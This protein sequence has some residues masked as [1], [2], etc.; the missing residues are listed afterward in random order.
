MNVQTLNR[1]SWQKC[2][3]ISFSIRSRI[4]SKYHKTCNILT[5]DPAINRETGASSRRYHL[6]MWTGWIPCRCNAHKKQVDV[7]QSHNPV[8]HTVRMS[9][10]QLQLKIELQFEAV[11]TSSQQRAWALRTPSWLIQ[12]SE[13]RSAAI[14]RGTGGQYV[15]VCSVSNSPLTHNPFATLL[16]KVWEV[17]FSKEA[18]SFVIIVDYVSACICIRIVVSRL[19]NKHCDWYNIPNP[20]KKIFGFFA[21]F[22][23]HTP[24]DCTCLHQ[25]LTLGDISVYV[26]KEVLQ[27][28]AEL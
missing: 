16:N 1:I 28:L 13:K 10:S 4:S 11:R 8:P 21:I 14:G 9:W 3:H 27:S 19:Y 12:Q 20:E 18:C 22:F 17:Y 23:L 7:K 26:A 15:A 6:D 2:F 25:P 24:F 5:F